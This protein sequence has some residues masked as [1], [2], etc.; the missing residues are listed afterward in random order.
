MNADFIWTPITESKPPIGKALIVTIFDS[1]RNRRELRYPVTYRQSF[2]GDGYG[3]YNCGVD[4]GYLMPEY[5]RVLAWAE[6]P[7][8]WDGDIDV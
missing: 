4:D 6:I 1:C 3:F 8:C 5:S 7:N 2:Y